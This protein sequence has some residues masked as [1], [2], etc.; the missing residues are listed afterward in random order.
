MA[1]TVQGSRFK[2]QSRRKFGVRHPVSEEES[3]KPKIPSTQPLTPNIQV[4]VV[5]EA[6]KC[7]FKA[8][9]IAQKQQAKSLELRV[10]ISL[11]RLRQYQGREAEA[12]QLL[13][14]SYSWFREGFATAD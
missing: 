9:D 7:F 6:E 13:E 4:K 3:Q 11:A 1:A 5:Q 14:N 12:R 8:I 10:A 2:V